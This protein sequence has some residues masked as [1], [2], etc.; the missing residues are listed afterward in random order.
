VRSAVFAGIA[1]NKGRDRFMRYPKNL[2]AI[3]GKPYQSVCPAN[4][5]MPLNGML[6]VLT[7]ND[8]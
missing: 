4:F 6:S 8:E 1:K 2:L 5:L 7:K 3:V